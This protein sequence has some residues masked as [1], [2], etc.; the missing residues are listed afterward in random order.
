MGYSKE[1]ERQNEVL[2]SLLK[3]ETPEKRVMVG[4]E[5]KPEEGG[6]KISHLSEVMKE[7]RMPWFC[8]NC[9]KVMK[10][11]LDNKFWMKFNHCFDR[12]DILWRFSIKVLY[13]TKKNNALYHPNPSSCQ[14]NPSP[15]KI[16]KV[17]CQT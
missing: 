3:G 17:R 6:D 1:A 9:K 10:Q 15:I 8:P 2:G 12:Q 7:A 13:Q 14:L 5:G 16:F 11:R 4:Y